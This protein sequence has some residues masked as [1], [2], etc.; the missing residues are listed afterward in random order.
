MMLIQG[1]NTEDSKSDCR[2]YLESDISQRMKSLKYEVTR[3]FW[4]RGSKFIE[5]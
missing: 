4:S 2:L 3:N 5:E 1:A